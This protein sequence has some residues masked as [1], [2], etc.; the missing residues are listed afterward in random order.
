MDAVVRRVRGP[1]HFTLIVFA[2][3]GLI[4]LALAVVGLF[5][6]VSY[7]VTR[8]SREIGVRIAL[9]ATPGRVVRLMLVQGAGPAAVGLLVGAAASRALSR[10]V[11]AAALRPQRRRSPHLRAGRAVL[12]SGDRDGE[13]PPGPARRAR[14]S[15]AGTAAR[16]K[17]ARPA[18][19]KLAKLPWRVARLPFLGEAITLCTRSVPHSSCS[20][21]C[22]DPVAPSRAEAQDV[23]QTPQRAQLKVFLDCESCYS[24]FL[25]T[26]IP[27][28]DYVRDRTEADVHL[29]IREARDGQRRP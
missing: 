15:A 27:F 24:D 18:C 13:L 25:R 3:F 11:P 26:E 6:V 7:A 9:G 17:R 19:R 16:V 10:A 2:L 29:M 4:A 8:R 20:A 21:A 1:W 12:R 22:V 5:A 28:V 23:R 14:R